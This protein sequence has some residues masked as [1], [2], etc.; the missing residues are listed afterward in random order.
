MCVSNFEYLIQGQDVELVTDHKPLLSM[1]HSKLRIKLERH[2]RQIEF[3]SQF[4]AKIRHVSGES[5]IVADA[6]SRIEAVELQR[7]ISLKDIA[8]AQEHDSDSQE[9]RRNSGEKCE[10]GDVFFSN[11]N[12]S[13]LCVKILGK[14][15]IIV[16]RKYR[17]IIFD[18]LH[19]IHHP[20]G[21][22]T[23]KLI[24]NSYYWPAAMQSEIRKWCRCC[25]ACQVSKVVRHTKARLETFP[26]S[27]RG[28]HVHTDIVTLPE[29][30]GYRYVITFIDRAM[31]WMEAK[32]LKS[33]EAED[34][35][36]AFLEI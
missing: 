1:F 8:E 14:Q 22:L 10:V 24:S 18:Q 34:V 36:R 20:A 21:R 33:T 3:I 13:V 27:D 35:A 28:D 19:G 9:L 5:N 25:M 11:E 4:S 29:I 7:P 2:S 30:D 12:V 31:R 32:P 15:H 23:I 17:R 16:P 26:P 6:M